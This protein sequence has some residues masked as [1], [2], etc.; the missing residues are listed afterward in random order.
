MVVD[1]GHRSL[2]AGEV[3]RADPIVDADTIPDA[4][5]RERM[6]GVD[7]VQQVAAGVDRSGECAEVIV[8]LA[9]GDRVEQRALG[10][11]R[12]GAVRRTV[13]VR[14]A[15]RALSAG[16]IGHRFEM[17]AHVP[18]RT[19]GRRIPAGTRGATGALVK[20]VAVSALLDLSAVRHGRVNGR[21]FRENFA[22]GGIDLVQIIPEL[23]TNADSAIALGGRPAGRIVLALRPARPR[24]RGGLERA[25]RQ[26]RAPALLDWR[27]ELR[28]ADD[29]V[30]MDAAAVDRRLGALGVLPDAGGQRG[31]FGRG[32]RDVWLA[33]GG[34]RLEGVRDGRRVESWFFP[35]GGDDPYAYLHVRDEASTDPPGTS[36]TV[37]LA[38]GRP[39]ANARLRRLV[40][41]RQDAAD[42]GHGT[43]QLD[44][45]RSRHA[46]KAN[47][48]DPSLMP[49]GG[50]PVLARPED[51]RAP[52]LLVL[53]RWFIQFSLKE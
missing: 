43:N 36:I 1:L 42:I 7:R 16:S 53:A 41:Q 23:V 38:A 12:R 28:C 20:V 11:H 13:M 35:S 46:P 51:G 14:P 15:A 40:G 49:N 48:G 2:E 19:S 45:S 32:L 30:G 3:A 27:H 18:D 17:F 4:E 24:V 52:S 25:M 21:Y 6:A 5:R 39:P 9:A 31:L 44:A 34:G 22:Q 29:G 37:P 8:E 50:T 47:K 33:Q 10:I 26:L